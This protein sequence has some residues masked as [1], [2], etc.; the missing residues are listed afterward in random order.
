MILFILLLIMNKDVLVL[1]L[2]HG[3]LC[4]KLK[5]FFLYLAGDPPVRMEAVQLSPSMNP[6]DYLRSVKDIAEGNTC[7]FLTDIA[8]GTPDNTARTLLMQDIKGACV[9]GVNVPMVIKILAAS[10]ND[11]GFEVLVKNLIIAG[12]DGIKEFYSAN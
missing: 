8:G 4:E 10:L 1:I 6:K 3:E 5:E 12:K 2:T 9:S 7:L 11:D